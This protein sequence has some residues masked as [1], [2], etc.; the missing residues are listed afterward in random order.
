MHT[1]SYVV[2]GA[3]VL[4]RIQV[5]AR[6][7]WHFQSLQVAGTE[8][9]GHCA[10]SFALLHPTTVTEYFLLCQFVGAEPSSVFKF[11]S[12]TN[13]LIIWGN[14]C[15]LSAT[16]ALISQNGSMLIIAFSSSVGN[17]VLP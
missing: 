16:A 6:T 5:G 2:A 9:I 10:K 7:T 14:W 12:F 4:E 13:V 15:L 17:S 3:T 11:E 1:D 8:S